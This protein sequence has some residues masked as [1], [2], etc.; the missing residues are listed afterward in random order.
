MF[1]LLEIVY[2]HAHHLLTYLCIYLYRS[3]FANHVC[4]CFDVHTHTR[5][6]VVGQCY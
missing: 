4:S 2:V 6:I 5:G 3:S 1:E